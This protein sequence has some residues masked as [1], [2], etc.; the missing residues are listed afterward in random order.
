M[1]VPIHAK[2]SVAISYQSD[3][4]G[5]VVL[6]ATN[7]CP[8]CRCVFCLEIF[9]AAMNILTVFKYQVQYQTSELPE[10]LRKNPGD[11]L[12]MHS[13]RKLYL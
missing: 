11:S 3:F 5:S 6:P 12:M 9:N 1:H 4:F 13:P 10:Y 7:Q 2:L 8:V